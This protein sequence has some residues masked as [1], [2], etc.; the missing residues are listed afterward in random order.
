LPGICSASR[1]KQQL[2]VCERETVDSAVRQVDFLDSEIA[3][4]ERRIAAEALAG[5]RSSG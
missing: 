4:V 3:H 1:A 5:R 2:P